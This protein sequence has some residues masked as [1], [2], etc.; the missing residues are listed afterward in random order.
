MEEAD[1]ELLHKSLNLHWDYHWRRSFHGA[2]TDYDE[3]GEGL[4][5]KGGGGLFA[6]DTIGTNKGRC[7]AAGWLEQTKAAAIA[8]GRAADNTTD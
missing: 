8:T 3:G 5:N 2:I 4:E 1:L 6:L 7:S